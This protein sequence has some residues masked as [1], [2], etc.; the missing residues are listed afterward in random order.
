M[1]AP[2]P[3]ESVRAVIDRDGVAFLRDWDDSDLWFTHNG[4]RIHWESMAHPVVPL[5]P[6]PDTATS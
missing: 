5:V 6:R 4:Y 3:D 1:T 2:E